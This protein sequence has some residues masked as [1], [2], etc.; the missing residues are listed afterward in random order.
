MTP[1]EGLELADRY[2]LDERLA[3]GGMG[4][5]WRAR[6]LHSGKD[7]AAKILRP[8]L[9]GDEIFLSRLR[10]EAANSRGLRHPNLAV[11]LDS[12]E[13]EGSGWIIMELVQGRALSDVLAERGSAELMG[14]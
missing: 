5:V 7:V 8:E 6:D 13:A 12:G 11:V 14:L 2:R 4:E 1:E 10:A 9:N 3:L